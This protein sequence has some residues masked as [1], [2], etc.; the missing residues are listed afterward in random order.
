MIE[1]RIKSRYTDNLVDRKAIDPWHKNEAT[2]NTD[3][4]N[5]RDVHTSMDVTLLFLVVV[6]DWI[7]NNVTTRHFD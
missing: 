4:T 2:Y 1:L 6:S 3:M 5:E 7:K